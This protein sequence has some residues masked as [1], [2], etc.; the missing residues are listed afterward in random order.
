[1]TARKVKVL[2]PDQA[3]A[4]SDFYREVNPQRISMT[5]I[6]SLIELK[7]TAER[8]C[9]T[10]SFDAGEKAFDAW[11]NHA[12]PLYAQ[13]SFRQTVAPHGSGYLVEWIVLSS[14][15]SGACGGAPLRAR[16]EMSS[17]GHVGKVTFSPLEKAF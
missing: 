10:S 9:Q 13:V 7:Q 12:K 1:M 5:P 8:Q 17:D 6:T 15:G 11:W 3:E 4:V 14:A 16:L 2:G